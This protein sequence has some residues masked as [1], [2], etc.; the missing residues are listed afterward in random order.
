[1]NVLIELANQDDRDYI[2]PEDVGDALKE[3]KVEKVMVDL[4]EIIAG[5][6]GKGCEDTSLCA[7]VAWKA[8]RK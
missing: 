3:N 2:T 4:L 8:V 6:V 7:F 1:M 5:Q